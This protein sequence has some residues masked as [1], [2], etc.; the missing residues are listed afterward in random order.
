MAYAFREIFED[1]CI[2]EKAFL[3]VLVPY[4]CCLSLLL[5]YYCLVRDI[6]AGCCAVPGLD[7]RPYVQFLH[8]GQACFLCFL[9]YF[10]LYLHHQLYPFHDFRWSVSCFEGLRK[11]VS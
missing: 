1:K 2:L 5:R 9:G 8:F 3:V 10:G 4:L 11:R 6:S 7:L